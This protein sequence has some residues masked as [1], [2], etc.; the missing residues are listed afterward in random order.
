[1][2][3][4]SLA[5]LDHQTTGLICH[6]RGRFSR[7]SRY[8]RRSRLVWLSLLCR[9]LFCPTT[10]NLFPLLRRQTLE[11]FESFSSYAALPLGQFAPFKQPFGIPLLFSRLHLRITL[12]GCENSL[13]LGIGK[14]VP[15]FG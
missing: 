5:S 6:R 2:A 13:T 12:H 1:M 7:R 15:V 8:R 9:V 4:L 11:L 14:L 3:L 10:P